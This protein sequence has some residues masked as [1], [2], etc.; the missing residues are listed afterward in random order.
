MVIVRFARVWRAVLRMGHPPVRWSLQ[1][2]TQ[3]GGTTAQ[4]QGDHERCRGSTTKLSGMW[5]FLD[6]MDAQ[7][8]HM[9]AGER[10]DGTDELV[11]PGE[12]GQ[13][14][15]DQLVARGTV[16]L[17]AVTWDSVRRACATLDVAPPAV[18]EAE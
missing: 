6:R 13:R 16:P 4:L 11:V 14:R 1:M 5:E 7:I 2:M 3:D 10:T 17:S 8:A 9:K 12:R 15:H 18:L